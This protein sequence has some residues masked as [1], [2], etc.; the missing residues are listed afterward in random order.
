MKEITFRVRIFSPE[1]GVT[2]TLPG[3]ILELE[4]FFTALPTGHPDDN[5]ETVIK[6]A[7]QKFAR[8][9]IGSRSD[10]YF[11]IARAEWIIIEGPISEERKEEPAKPL[12]KKTK[13]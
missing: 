12:V 6:A 10:W 5:V 11:Q 4:E 9:V 13:K 3:F 2:K 7:A 8:E 1:Q